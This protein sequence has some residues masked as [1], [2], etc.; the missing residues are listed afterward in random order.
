MCG[1]CAEGTTTIEG[2][3]LARVWATDVDTKMCPQMA[4]K[5]LGVNAVLSIFTDND[6]KMAGITYQD[7]LL[8]PLELMW[9]KMELILG[10]NDFCTKM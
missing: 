3:I 6:I 7:L 9:R 2:N 8:F 10:R 5:Y 4:I 1:Q